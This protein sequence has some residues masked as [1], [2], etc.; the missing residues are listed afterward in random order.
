MA[1]IDLGGKTVKQL[2]EESIGSAAA[3][4]VMKEVNDAHQQGK[5]VEDIYQIFT[6]AVK[7][8]GKTVPSDKSDILFGFLAPAHG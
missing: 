8:E 7:N 5:P 2:L 6:D 4:R 1:Q 3:G